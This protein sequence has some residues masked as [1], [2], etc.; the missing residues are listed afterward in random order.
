MIVPIYVGFDPREAVAYHTF[1][2][3]V[4]SR[5]S[6][7]VSFIPLHAPLLN[8]FDGQRDGTNAFIYSRFLVPYLCGYRGW[9]IFVDGD[10]VVTDD[11]S[12][13]WGMRNDHIFDK[14]LCVVKHDY[15][16]RHRRKYI[17]SPIENDNAD[18]PKKNQS[19]VI[20]WN[21]GHYGNRILTPEFV[22]EAPGSLLHRFEWLRDEQIGELPIEW[23]SLEGESS[24]SDDPKLIHHTLGIPG[25]KHYAASK[26]SREWNSNLID[27]LNLSGENPA[28]MVKRA[29][30][31]E[32]WR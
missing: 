29:K 11:I 19:S 2:Q 8:N 15:K 22:R 17:G 18:Y 30:E 23:N 31:H 21:C 14:A 12:K 4:I 13:L 5:S 26:Y 32:E 16:T 1:C 10:M 7:P 9:A 20:L 3:S 24:C 6:V 25:F 27:A 28:D